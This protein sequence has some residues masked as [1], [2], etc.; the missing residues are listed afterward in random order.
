MGAVFLEVTA[1]SEI[2]NTPHPVQTLQLSTLSASGSDKTMHKLAVLTTLIAIALPAPAFASDWV[3]AG[4]SVDGVH[5]YI[6]RQSLRTMPNGYR[7]VWHKIDVTKAD[8]SVGFSAKLYE[9][10]DCIEKRMRNLAASITSFYSPQN[11]ASSNK[12]GEWNYVPPDSTAEALLKFIC[13]K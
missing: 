4:N 13:R 9:E 7:R 2:G 6:D 5:H 10:H 1:L 11:N 12:V 3:L 8:K